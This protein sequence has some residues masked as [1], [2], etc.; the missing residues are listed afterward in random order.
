[1]ESLNND[2]V[3]FRVPDN[4]PDHG[5]CH[6]E[7][8][9]CFYNDGGCPDNFLCKDGIFLS[10][11]DEEKALNKKFHEQK[12]ENYFQKVR[13]TQANIKAMNELLSTLI[14]KMLHHMEMMQNDN[15]I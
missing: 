10:K 5:L 15:F 12:F 4:H 6:Y 14:D 1:M 11:E 8:I 9:D 3:F 7:K 13:D 2:V